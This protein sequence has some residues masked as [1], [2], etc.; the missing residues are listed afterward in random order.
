MDEAVFS[1]LARSP[2]RVPLVIA[3]F[4]QLVQRLA[5]SKCPTTLVLTVPTHQFIASSA[6]ESRPAVTH[7]TV[8]AYPL[9]GALLFRAVGMAV[10]VHLVKP[11]CSKGAGSLETITPLVTVTALASVR[12]VLAESIVVTGL[13]RHQVIWVRQTSWA[14]LRRN[15][16]FSA[17]ALAPE[18]FIA[19]QRPVAA[20]S[21]ARCILNEA[22]TMRVAS[23]PK[24]MGGLVL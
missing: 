11:A 21:E 13:V 17:I 4:R 23:E 22:Q 18:I 15:C 7:P 24:E 19:Q 20:P 10:P 1:Y 6:C 5:T 2:S 8:G 12:A 9:P 16:R 3:V 14:L